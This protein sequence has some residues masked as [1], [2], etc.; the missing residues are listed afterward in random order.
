M[1]KNTMLLLSIL[2]SFFTLSSVQQA[3]STDHNYYWMKITAHD[4]FERSV[5]ANLGVAIEIVK[6]DYVIAYGNDRELEKLKSMGKLVAASNLA[7]EPLDFPTSDAAYHNYTELVEAMQTLAKQNP[8]LVQMTSIAKTIEGHD[9][10]ALR[11]TSDFAHADQKPAAIY[12]GGH[13]AREH[14]SVEMPL[15]L[16]QYLIAQYRANNPRIVGLVNSR[17]IHIIPTVNPDGMEYDIKDT[18][19][20]MWRKNRARNSDGTYGVDLNRNYGFQWGTGGSSTDTESEVYMGPKAFSEVESTAIKNYIEAHVNITTLLSFHSFSKLILYPW[21][22]KYD[23][24]ENEKAKAVHETMAKKMATWNDY[25][26][27]QA[28]GLYIASGDTTDW[29]FGV[30]QIIS[31]TFELDPA[32]SGFGGGGFYPGAGVIQPVFDKNIEPMLYLLEYADNPY[33][34]LNI[35][36]GPIKP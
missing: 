2:F 15:M 30:H 36:I 13:H 27:G 21:G 19:Y 10:W 33:R 28:S 25:E 14:L 24:I 18:S 26:P 16:A 6:D 7:L 35:G 34:V 11:I 20:K 29:A 12:M 31:F 3:K 1:K 23:G 8:D 32:N 22:H 4:K 9:M 17:D 5:I